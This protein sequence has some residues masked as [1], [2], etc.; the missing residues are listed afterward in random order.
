MAVLNGVLKDKIYLPL[1]C[2]SSIDSASSTVFLQWFA[3]LENRVS[4]CTVIL[5]TMN[6]FEVISVTFVGILLRI[7]SGCSTKFCFSIL[8]CKSLSMRTFCAA[9]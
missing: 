2:R 9:K 8:A 3:A 5:F 1:F 7:V 6:S 4:W